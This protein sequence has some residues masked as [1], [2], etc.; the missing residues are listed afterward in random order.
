[1][2]ILDLFSER[3]KDAL[4]NAALT[5]INKNQ[6]NIDTEHILFSLTQDEVVMARIFKELG[7]D[8]KQL[9][10]Q[11]EDL[12]SEG[13]ASDGRTP[14]L[15][16]R[17]NQV[18]QLAYQESLALNHNYIGT[19][20]IFLGLILEGEGLAAQLLNR[21]GI[22]HVKAR[23]AV[24]K[25]VGEGVKD[26]ADLQTNSET[27]NLDKF[28]KDLTD[29]ARQGKIDPVIGR[30]DEI[31]R[32]IE[33]LSRRKKNNPVLIGEPGVGKTAIA[34][35]LAQRIVEGSVPEI[36]KHKKVKAL[37]IGM[38]L[39]GS[40]F[41]GEFEERAKKLVDEIEKS[42][43]DVVL[44]IDELHTIVGSGSREGEMDLA[45][46][47]KPS[48]A[49]G[50]LQMI[51]ATTLNEY[52]KYI[53]K[54]AALERRFQPVLVKEPTIDQ[55]IL[56]LKGIKE[57]YE[58][59]HRL[60]ISDEAL[61]A[62]AKLSERYIQERF[63][64]DKAIDV[65]D[66]AASRVRLKF[67]SEPDQIREL[68]EQIKK[69]ERERESL[70]RSNQ[71]KEAAELKVKAEQIKEELRPLEEQWNR[72]RGTGSPEVNVEQIKET[73][74]RMTG[75][76]V[77][78][79]NDVVK[80]TLLNLDDKLKQ[81]VIGQSEAVTIVANAVRRSRVGLQ[82]PNRPIATFLF[83]GPTGVGKTELAK[84]LAAA[85]FSSEENMIRLDMSEYMDKFNVSKLIG[86]PP[87]YVGYE[88]GGQL[89]EKV[90]R[91][92]Y[93]VVLFDEIE[94][95]HPDVMNILLQVFE[96]GRLTDAK[97]RTVDFKNTIIICTSNI[98]S[99]TILQNLVQTNIEKLLAGN[100]AKSDLKLIKLKSVESPVKHNT[101]SREQLH[102]HLHQELQ[103]HF[104]PE[105][106]NRIDE[107][108]I[109]N[110][111]GRKEIGEIV[112]LELDKTKKLLTSRGIRLTV[113][114]NA[115]E[116]LIEKSINLE[117]GARPVRRVI[118]RE[119][120]N[121]ISNYLL[122]HEVKGEELKLSYATGRF[123][124]SEN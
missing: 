39:A 11:V 117:F 32:V 93:S 90:R 84:A 25:V 67:T 56:I 50:E 38:L 17:A 118:Q 95:A 1:M 114:D 41:R 43:R 23:Q 64:P 14:G 31:S 66:E 63:L 12:M 75:I 105:F 109:F 20:H 121:L 42:E 122:E 112:K 37:D 49:R 8:K 86:S 18:L 82:N 65:I 85:V 111:L 46:M 16:P 62:A 74:G 30:N 35:G 108:V 70:T 106:I 77:S 80:K 21:Y 123:T 59:H 36:L 10:A 79:M 27:P 97:G 124:I 44:F 3:A 103:K 60:K 34:E 58:A 2:N 68:K 115:I 76:P 119:V 57:R 13:V 107:I 6:R 81:R 69:L 15:A 83:M 48:L 91:Q 26:E 7:L 78:D 98:G 29:L 104:K 102:E 53:E 9:S 71:L 88:E 40:K 19:E 96:D 110:A 54:D 61:E 94:K 5:A 92:P 55:T 33:I 100:E 28:S 99:Q 120:E 24:V 89:T 22:G 113:S 51:G 87:G 45:N 116:K 47:L 4:Q 73:I 101:L 72:E 52:Q